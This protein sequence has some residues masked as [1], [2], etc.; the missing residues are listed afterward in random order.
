MPAWACYIEK[1][2]A[3]W[4]TYVR[5]L[6]FRH[7]VTRT[8]EKHVGQVTFLVYD[9]REAAI[10]TVPWR[11]RLASESLNTSEGRILFVSSMS[12]VEV[13]VKDR[14]WMTTVI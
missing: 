8:D 12:K 5:W 10:I 1:S 6:I 11:G 9:T 2:D 14:T 7:L 13:Q 4:P 3:N